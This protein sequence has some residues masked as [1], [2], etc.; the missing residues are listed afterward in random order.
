MPGAKLIINANDFG[1]DVEV[2]E[3]IIKSFEDGF[4][5]S[6]SVLMNGS[7]HLR[8]LRFAKEHIRTFVEKRQV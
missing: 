8:A 4:L 5:T 1:K 3:A 7:D 2:N 6:A